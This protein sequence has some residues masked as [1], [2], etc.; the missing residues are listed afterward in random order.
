MPP[1]GVHVVPS[2]MSVIVG[3]PTGTVADVQNWQ[4]GNTL[5]IQ[6]VAAAP[7]Q[8]I[9]FSFT[10]IKA[11][12]RIGLSM[13]YE[14]SATHWIEVRLWSYVALAYKTVWTFSITFGL[15]Y[16]YSD[17]PVSADEFIDPSGNAKLQIHHPT[18]GNAA[19]DSRIDYVA[20]IT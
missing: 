7:A 9:E 11:I 10:D 19:H 15:N 8:N 6:E 18:A 17:L 5:H 1:P 13:V 16:R 20:L 14:G 3:T 4:D 12:R 2:S